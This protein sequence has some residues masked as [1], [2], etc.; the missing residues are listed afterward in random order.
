MIKIIFRFKI[1][2][3]FKKLLKFKVGPI[4]DLATLQVNIFNEFDMI[5][6]RK[7]KSLRIEFKVLFY[8]HIR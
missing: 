2:L 8:T 4:F 7:M 5:F 6:Y 1:G 3:V